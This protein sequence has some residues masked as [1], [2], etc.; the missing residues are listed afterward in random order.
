MKPTFWLTAVIALVGCG[1]G[2]AAA[3]AT[4][5]GAVAAARAA[6]SEAHIAPCSLLSA[7]EVGAILGKPIVSQSDGNACVYGLDPSVHQPP[8][9]AQGGGKSG[10]LSGLMSALGQGGDF[11]K[12]AGAIAQQAQVTLGFV[13]DGM[14]EAAVRAIYTRTGETARGALQPEARGLQGVIQPEEEIRGVGDWA[15]ATNVASL[16]MGPGFSSRGRILETKRGAWHVTLTAVVSPDPGAGALDRQLAAI[17]RAAFRK[18][19][20]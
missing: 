5:A 20:S 15:F 19:P 2:R 9:A 8:T 7:T 16:Q 11:S 18:L 1:N 17:A 6:N 12:L 10:S 4:Q 13:Q 14:T 3:P